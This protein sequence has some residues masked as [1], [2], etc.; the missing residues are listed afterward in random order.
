KRIAADIR[1]GLC[2]GGCHDGLATGASAGGARLADARAASQVRPLHREVSEGDARA[3]AAGTR[4]T[5]RR[6]EV[7]HP[8]R[9]PAS[10]RAMPLLPCRGF[11][12]ALNSLPNS[13]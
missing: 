3:A 4:R 6:R 10:R 1:T 7:V 2:G 11:R 8:P 12:T 13:M 9:E 5:G